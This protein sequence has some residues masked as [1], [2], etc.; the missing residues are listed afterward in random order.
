MY[1]KT[2]PL[3]KLVSQI[4]RTKAKNLCQRCGRYTEYANLQTAHCWGRR[5]KSVRYDLENVL[6]LCFSCHRIIDSESPEDKREVFIRHL[7]EKGYEALN[8]RANW[9]HQ[10][11]PDLK[12]IKFY[13]ENELKHLKN[14]R[15]SGDSSK[16]GDRF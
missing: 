7:G 12:A 5:K 2:D 16:P 9:P 4:T 10:Y 1:I 13:L 11:K 14:K 8:Q 3:D 15:D 6:A